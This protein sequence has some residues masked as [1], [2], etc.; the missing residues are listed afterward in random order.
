[1]NLRQ[2]LINYFPFLGK[3]KRFFVAL[4][5]SLSSVKK[6][7][8]QN[9][10]D[11]IIYDILKQS[12]PP[13][14]GYIDIGS[15]H[16]T[17]ISN[18]YLLYRTGYCGYL[19]EPNKELCSLSKFIRVRDKIINIGIG[20]RPGILPFYVS[21]TPVGSSFDNKH[22]SDH[23]QQLHRVEYVPVMGLDDAF[24]QFNLLSIGLISIDVEGWNFDVVRSAEQLIN[25]A[26]VLCIE[27]DTTEEREQILSTTSKFGLVHDNGCNLIMKKMNN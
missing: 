4:H 5:D 6:T 7:Y 2:I 20:L 19:V 8:A 11:K 12:P 25:K 1:M 26:I 18:T 14:I 23:N 10:E 15:N 27:Y 9:N 24:R 17:D 13:S 16:P 22:L 3:Y 21:R